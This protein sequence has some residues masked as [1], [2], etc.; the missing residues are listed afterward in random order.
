MNV[1]QHP[2]LNRS[3]YQIDHDHVEDGRPTIGVVVALWAPQ[4]SQADAETSHVLTLTTVEMIRDLGGRPIV[5]DG[6]DRSQQAHGTSWQQDIDA[7]VF[8]GGADVHPGFYTDIELSEELPGIDPRADQFAVDAVRQAISDNTP[9]LGICRGAQLL[10]VA[11]GGSII[12]HIDGHRSELDDGKTGFIDETVNLV[13]DSKIAEILG[14][15]TISVRSSHH[16]TI[17][18]VGRGLVVTAYAQDDSIEGVEYPDNTWVVGL[19]WH[20]EE[21]EANAEDRH[22]IFANLLAQVK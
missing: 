6:S 21:A 4:M 2:G 22:Q 8:L 10:N 1:S 15:T 19:Q 7:I 11:L 13:A 14:R 17:N 9:V 20:P 12:Q 16:Q 5:I 18:E 3:D